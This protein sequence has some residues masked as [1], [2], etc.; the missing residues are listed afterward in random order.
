M[1]KVIVTLCLI[2][3]PAHCRIPIEVVPTSN[4][5]VG[6]M[7]CLKGGIIGTLNQDLSE[8]FVKVKCVAQTPSE[9]DTWLEDYK[10]QN[11]K[12][13]RSPWN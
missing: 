8:W 1:F 2:S 7:A 3:N 9:F 10:E 6:L 4:Q 13:K 5:P 11:A 12:I